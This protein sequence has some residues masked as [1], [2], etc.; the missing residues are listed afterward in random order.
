MPIS[1]EDL[2]VELD[3]KGLPLFM[4]EAVRLAKAKKLNKLNRV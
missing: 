1:W 3:L 4:L 2:F